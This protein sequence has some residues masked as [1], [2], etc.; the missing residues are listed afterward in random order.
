M[1]HQIIFSPEDIVQIVHAFCSMVG[2][3]AV[4]VGAVAAFIAWLKKPK[5]KRL[6]ELADHEKRI[7]SLE[8]KCEKYQSFFQEQDVRFDALEKETKVY[9]RGMLALI[10]HA[11]SGNNTEELETCREE[12]TDIVYSPKTEVNAKV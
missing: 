7:S 3:I 10:N 12:L 1:H 4:V 9:Q 2:E 5:E 11:L 8:A 6:A